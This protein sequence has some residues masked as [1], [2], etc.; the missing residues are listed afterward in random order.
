MNRKHIEA[1]DKA[2]SIF[3]RQRDSFNGIHGKCCTCGKID[4]IKK[5]HCGHF[6]SRRHLAT[7]WEEQNCSLQ[8]VGCNLFN[9]GKQYEFSLFLDKK[10]GDGTADKMRIKSQNVCKMSD[11]EAKILIKHYKKQLVCKK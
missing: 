4:E 3:I 9:Q 1:L 11:T 5:M 6:M 8:C 7:R 10:F 2:F